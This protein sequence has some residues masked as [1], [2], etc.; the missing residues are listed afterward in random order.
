MLEPAC[1]TGNF[2]GAM[3]G[4]IRKGV[5]SITMVELD[6]ITGGIARLLYPNADVRVQGFEESRLPDNYF[7]AA[8]GNVPFGNFGIKDKTYPKAVTGAI[9]NY[10][11]AKSLDKV[12]EGG[13]VCF[14]TSRYT[15]DANHN[16]VRRYIADRADLIGA[17]RLPDTAFKAN[18]G[19]EAVTDIL[20]FKK[21]RTSTPYRGE[22]F[23]KSEYGYIEGTA[24]GAEE[25]E[26]GAARD[27]GIYAV[28]NEYFKAH[29]DMVLGTPARGKLY[30]G[31]GLT[32]K[33]LKGDL[34]R[35]I[36]KA[37][38]SITV[39][40]DYPAVQ[41]PEQVREEIKKSG[42]GV[43]N[44]S[45]R[46]RDGRVYE[47][48]DGTEVATDKIKAKD[49]K[50]AEGIINIRDRARELL[51]AQ[52]E[53]R[54]EEAIKKLRQELN[55]A[56][57]D[58]TRKYGALF[59]SYN[60][61]IIK[62]D[63]DSAFIFALEN[64]N[65][66]QTAAAKADIFSI[67]TL[68]PVVTITHT[69]SYEDAL[70]VSLNET[71]TV[72]MS[73][74]A[75]LMDE[76]PKTVKK[77]LTERKLIFKNR[78]GVYEPAEVYLSGNVRAKLK[79]AEA[80]AEADPDYKTNVE[81]LKK[82]IPADIAPEDIK[83]RP[84]MTWIP[85]SLYTEFMNMMLGYRGGYYRPPMTVEFNRLLGEYIVTQ[86]GRVNKH[87]AENQS[88]WGTGYRNGSF[89]DIF[90]ATLNSK[91]VTIT[92]KSGDKRIADKAATA[93]AREKQ[94]RITE[95]FSQWLWE[96][97]KRREQLSRLYNDTFNSTVTP[98]YDGGRLTINGA[99][100]DKPLREHQKNAVARIIN[101]GGNTLLAHKVGAG[102]TYEMA[103]AA[104]KLKQLGI[105]KKPLF[106]VPKSLTGQW[107][108]EFL[109]FFP[110]ANILV[111]GDNDF[112]AQNRRRYANRIAVGSYDAVIMSYEQFY[113]VPMT[114]DYRR[115]F[116]QEQVDAFTAAI[117]EERLRSGKAALSVKNLEKARKGFEKKIAD[118]GDGKRDE[119]NIDFEELG[120]DA[121]FVDEAHNFKNLFFTT[122]MTNVSGLGNPGG[123]QKTLD[124]Y[125]KVRYLQSLNGGRG[126]V[127][128]TA[129]PVMNSM[130]EMYIM[131]KY[132][133]P[134]P[135]RRRG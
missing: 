83:V 67:N 99:N 55:K 81:E 45:L 73:R 86:T 68:S 1:G 12:R 119:D 15:M 133:Q 21:R 44:G 103:A 43:K 127:F 64:V 122:H 114:L 16:G 117:E 9:H 35:Q 7:D 39:K 112:S 27:T 84:G 105:I 65:K 120:I 74:I 13:V 77:A 61:R 22:P 123:N 118:L 2:I 59:K 90:T 95:R 115:G 125:M 121:L 58:F 101:S 110:G 47:T 97:D 56:Y 60:R 124:L 113:A 80:L 62:E 19:T 36:A 108:K 23:L 37:F 79:D 31:D 128:A 72:D 92:K 46:I 34:G 111:L 82:I 107:G 126:I 41:S 8:V 3:P 116:Y 28:V 14:I 85:D 30:S 69:D 42:R 11:F 129:T 54:S 89:I 26:R 87:S 93:A 88:I 78:D 24:R 52:L 51:N 98:R 33:A 10:F 134:S 109:D 6:S 132:L 57:D 4:S 38:K 40:M 76:A 94:E 104:M 63:A 48:K 29:P 131:Q 5:N 130:S 102:K 49:I 135:L 18:A 75:S 50:R 100:A 71:G 25:T 96:D 66:D 53:G 32:Y 106:I 70:T 20:V 91:S 17:I